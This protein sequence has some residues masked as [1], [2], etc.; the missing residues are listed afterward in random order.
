MVAMMV[1]MQ[2][3]WAPMLVIGALTGL[4]ALIPG[5]GWLLGFMVFALAWH[6]AR[7]KHFLSDLAVLM[8]VWLLVRVL[9]L[10]LPLIV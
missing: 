3:H 10:Q 4:L 5:V 6:Y 8:L 1:N 2:R 9:A 7:R